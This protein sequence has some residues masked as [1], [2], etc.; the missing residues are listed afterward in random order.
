MQV[1][2]QLPD[3]IAQQLGNA[4]EIPRRLLE[5]IVLQQYLA[6]RI[7]QGKL[8]QILGLSRWEA[9]DFL[10]S[11]NARHPYTREMIEE[12]RRVLQELR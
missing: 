4:A 7:P 6:H 2:I 1:T 12:D 5:A 3:E 9:E 8:A 10:D 11:H